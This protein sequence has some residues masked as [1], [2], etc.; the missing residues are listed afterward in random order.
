MMHAGDE[1]RTVSAIVAEPINVDLITT[2]IGIDLEGD[3]LPGVGAD[4]GRVTFD[5]RVARVGDRAVDRP[6]ALRRSRLLIFGYDLVGRV[7]K[8]RRC[9]LA[10]GCSGELQYRA[11]CAPVCRYLPVRDDCAV[12]DSVDIACSA[13]GDAER[14]VDV[15]NAVYAG[16]AGQ[17]DDSECDRAS[18]CDAA[19]GECCGAAGRVVRLVGCDGYRFCAGRSRTG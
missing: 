4:L 6:R 13:I 15:R 18:R 8:C 17:I 1:R 16:T 7:A 5:L 14:R 3:G 9:S 19:N 12:D 10:I 2:R 11:C